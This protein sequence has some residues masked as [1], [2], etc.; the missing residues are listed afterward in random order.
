MHNGFWKINTGEISSTSGL[1][2]ASGLAVRTSAHNTPTVD[3]RFG[4]FTKFDSFIHQ[5]RHLDKLEKVLQ[6]PKPEYPIGAN[7][8]LGLANGSSIIGIAAWWVMQQPENCFFLLYPRL[9]RWISWCRFLWWSWTRRIQ[10]PIR[11]HLELVLRLIEPISS[12]PQHETA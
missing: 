12:S 7:W 3:H 10:T 2:L 6:D 9:K 1:S 8:G 5:V 11:T 4:A